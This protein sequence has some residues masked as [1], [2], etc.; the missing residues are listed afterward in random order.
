MDALHRRCVLGWRRFARQLGLAIYN[1]ARANNGSRAGP[2]TDNPRKSTRA[3][4][5]ERMSRNVFGERVNPL[6]ALMGWMPL[7]LHQSHAAEEL[8][9]IVNRGG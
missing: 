9:N 1:G 7:S 4:W 6:I 5:A 8:E 2:W 3:Y